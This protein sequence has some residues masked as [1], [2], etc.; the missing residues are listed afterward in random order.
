MNRFREYGFWISLTGA[1]ILL[2]QV[3]GNEF[4]FRINE[5]FINQCVTAF[6]GVLV[7]A[8]I[9]IKPNH[10]DN[11]EGTDETASVEDDKEDVMSDNNTD[12]KETQNDTS[13]T[14]K[15]Q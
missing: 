11:D 14:D 12:T 13:H 1:I 8:G 3:I 4:G 9:L 7:V 5:N 10:D 15:E 2:L 6:C